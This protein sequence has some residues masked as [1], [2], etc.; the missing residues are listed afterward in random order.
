MLLN[1]FFSIFSQKKE[2]LKQNYVKHNI[3]IKHWRKQ[4]HQK[5]YINN[6]KK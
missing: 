4:Q 2:T 1:C 3:N 5:I 6:N